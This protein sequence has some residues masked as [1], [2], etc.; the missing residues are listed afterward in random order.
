MYMVA[1]H[2]FDKQSPALKE[3]SRKLFEMVNEVTQQDD[4]HRRKLAQ[5]KK[6]MDE[7]L[8]NIESEAL[9]RVRKIEK[10]KVRS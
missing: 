8:Q 5:I 4:P 3:N 1:Y 10:E 7:E 9:K 6:E 2:A